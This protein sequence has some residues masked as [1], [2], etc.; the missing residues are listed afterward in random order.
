MNYVRKLGF[1]ETPDYDFMRDLFTKALEGTGEVEDGIYDWMLLNNGKG[2]QANSVS[3]VASVDSSPLSFP[4]HT[5]LNPPSTTFLPPIPPPTSHL[6]H[7]S[8]PTAVCSTIMVTCGRVSSSST[9][10]RIRIFSGTADN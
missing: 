7:K 2:W 9:W 3:L 5:P 6:S 1:E 8:S 4:S 10:P